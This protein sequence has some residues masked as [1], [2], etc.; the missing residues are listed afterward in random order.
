MG[1]GPLE[2]KGA[3]IG[4]GDLPITVLLGNICTTGFLHVPKLLC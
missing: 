4:A 2:E 3:T 1:L